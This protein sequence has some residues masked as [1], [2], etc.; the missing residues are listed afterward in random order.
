MEKNVDAYTLHIGT[1]KHVLHDEI[2]TGLLR[3]TALFPYRV[4]KL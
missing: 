3:I 2:I 1:G 4:I